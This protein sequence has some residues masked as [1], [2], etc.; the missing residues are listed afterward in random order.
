MKSLHGLKVVSKI[1][2]GRHVTMYVVGKLVFLV[3][4]VQP[5][6]LAKII[7]T[8]GVLL[9]RTSNLFL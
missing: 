3:N 5:T 1:F 6:I 9:I 7:G 8:T 2:A 4:L